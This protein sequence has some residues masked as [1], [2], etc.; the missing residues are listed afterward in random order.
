MDVESNRWLGVFLLAHQHWPRVGTSLEPSGYK[1]GQPLHP[2]I[3]AEGIWDVTGMNRAVTSKRRGGSGEERFCQSKRKPRALCLNEW[4]HVA[5]KRTS[6]QTAHAPAAVWWGRSVKIP[7][8]LNLVCGCDRPNMS[9]YLFKKW[10]NQ[11]K[12]SI[13]WKIKKTSAV[14]SPQTLLKHLL[15]FLKSVMSG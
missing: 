10:H 8:A 12:Y 14:S 7:S 15:S 4:S 1:A 11:W 3:T 2:L 9:E 5:F 6:V 13:K